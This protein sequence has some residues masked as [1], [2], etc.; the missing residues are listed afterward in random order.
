MSYIAS[1]CLCWFLFSDT[2]CSTVV[3]V[4]SVYMPTDSTG[5]IMRKRGFEFGAT[6]GRS[7]RCGWFDV[8][9]IRYV[10][11]VTPISLIHFFFSPKYATEDFSA[12]DAQ[13]A[14][15]F[16]NSRF[17]NAINKFT[18]LNLTKLDV[19]TGLKKLKICVAYRHKTTG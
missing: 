3:V 12:S 2:L 5:E 18:S 8:P 10:G 19:L 1:R 11:N 15:Y 4:L 7:R 17:S 13:L 14:C 6:T 16:I 9:L